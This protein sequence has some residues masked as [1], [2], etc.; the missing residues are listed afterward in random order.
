MREEEYP[1]IE[2]LLP[3]SELES[4]E[5]MEDP[6]TFQ[7]RAAPAWMGSPFGEVQGQ[8]LYAFYR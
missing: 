2:L 3:L 4:E 5:G 8:P 7:L 1:L 6:W